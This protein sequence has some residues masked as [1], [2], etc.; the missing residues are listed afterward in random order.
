[1]W[2]VFQE[3]APVTGR[4]RL[5]WV[6]QKKVEMKIQKEI[7]PVFRALLRMFE[8]AIVSVD[9]PM[10]QKIREV[11]GRLTAAGGLQ[12]FDWEVCLIN[13]P[14]KSHFSNGEQ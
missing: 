14:G 5:N 2:A 4:W 11:L 7:R 10:H 1:M 9:H 13:A 3:Q 12:D 8:K 6:S